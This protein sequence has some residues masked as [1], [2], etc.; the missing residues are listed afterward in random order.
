MAAQT[1]AR[2]GFARAAAPKPNRGGQG[3]TSHLLLALVVVAVIGY[4]WWR[5]RQPPAEVTRPQA[6][7]ATAQPMTAA[8]RAQVEADL[9]TCKK[10]GISTGSCQVDPG[11][12]TVYLHCNSG[13][14]GDNCE[15]LC[16]TGASTALVYKAGYESGAPSAATCVCPSTSHFRDANVVGGCRLGS[17]EGSQ[18]APGWH[19]THCDQTG[20]HKD[21]GAHGKQSA[22]TGDCV[23]TDGYQGALCNRPAD[24]CT[25]SDAGAT[26]DAASDSCKCTGA[27]TGAQCNVPPNCGSRGTLDRT[28][29][30]CTCK[31]GYAGSTCSE[32]A[33]GY[34]KASDGTCAKLLDGNSTSLTLT[35]GSNSGTLPLCKIHDLRNGANKNQGCPT[36]NDLYPQVNGCSKWDCFKN[37]NGTILMDSIEVP[38]GVGLDTYY[39]GVTGAEEISTLQVGGA[40]ATVEAGGSW[41]HDV[42]SGNPAWEPRCDAA[43]AQSGECTYTWGNSG[44]W[45]N[46]GDL[47]GWEV[48]S[49]PGY[50]ITGCATDVA[51][52][53]P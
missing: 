24:Y 30:K 33:A 34:E 44:S 2:T 28:T 41:S 13:Y 4:V 27:W 14:Y 18:C 26:Y 7:A 9:A 47:V 8:E 10:R 23:C 25:G 46:A 29:M 32:C 19:G 21:C 43:R 36:L 3:G 42:C 16:A 15:D 40:A 52:C 11:N 38:Q 51:P 53:A 22:T 50:K 1:P 39:T 12:N 20:A 49:R 45:T 6:E 31:P 37:G 35:N 5:Q 17:P 48:C